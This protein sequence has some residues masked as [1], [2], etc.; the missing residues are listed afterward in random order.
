VAIL[1]YI[2]NELGYDL[3]RKIDDALY[4]ST[5]G[6]GDNLHYLT[7]FTAFDYAIPVVKVFIVPYLLTYPF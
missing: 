3:A 4:G 6:S 7:I 2:V 5:I 1:I